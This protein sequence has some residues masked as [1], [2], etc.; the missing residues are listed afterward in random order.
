[1]DI[2]LPANRSVTATKVIIMIHG[3][4]WTGGD[5]ADFN[6]MIDTTLKNGCPIARS[7]TSITGWLHG[8]TIYFRRD[9]RL[10]AAIRFIFSNRYTYLVSNKIRFTNRIISLPC[11]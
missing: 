2:Y 7:S 10:K 1:M 3:G 6:V 5:K 8:P 9:A 11:L 4:G